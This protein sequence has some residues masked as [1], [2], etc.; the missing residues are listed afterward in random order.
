[1]MLRFVL[2]LV[3]VVCSAMAR[4]QFGFPGAGSFGSGFPGAGSFGS[5]FGGAGNGLAIGTGIGQAQAP[6]GGFGI[7]TGVGGAITTP[8]GNQAIGQ[9]LG[10]SVGK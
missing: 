6:A 2:A 4:P 10:L 1:M 3:V 8:F 9:G 7:G 5:G